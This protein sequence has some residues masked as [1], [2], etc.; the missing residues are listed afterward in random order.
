MILHGLS[1]LGFAARA[2]VRTVGG[3]TLSSLRYLNARFTAPVIPGDGLE[4]SAWKVGFGP[5]DVTEVAF[6]VRDLRTGQVGLFF[7]PC[8]RPDSHPL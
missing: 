5:G 3:G 8:F 2:L 4:T 7:C 1:T 6:E